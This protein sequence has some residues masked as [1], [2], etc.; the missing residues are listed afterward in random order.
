MTHE[1]EKPK[2]PE[3]LPPEVK[4]EI[5]REVSIVAHQESYSGPLPP[6]SE[7]AK[8]NETLPG[9]AERILAMA[10]KEQDFRQKQMVKELESKHSLQNSAIHASTEFMRRGQLIAAVLAALFFSAAAFLFVKE[11][12]LLG[13]AILLGIAGLAYVF[14]SGKY[15]SG[16]DTP[17][18]SDEERPEDE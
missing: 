1:E 7:F 18:K 3:V 9:A 10:E 5:Q 12:Y 2:E 17:L 13:T 8:Y 16:K 14:I 15:K 6:A 4:A 11:Q